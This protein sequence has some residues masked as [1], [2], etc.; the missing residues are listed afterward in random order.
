MP[1]NTAMP[2]D[3]RALAP[4]PVASTRG[5]TLRMKANEVMTIGRNRARAASTAASI[6][7]LL[8]CR[9]MVA[10]HIDDQNGVLGRERDQQND[11]VWV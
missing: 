5:T 9:A 10:R 1:L 4:A 8:S 11:A 3:C 2:I 7:D 6:K